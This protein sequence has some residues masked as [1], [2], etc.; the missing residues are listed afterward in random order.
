[1]FR[2]VFA[3]LL[4][5]TPFSVHAADQKK[6]VLIAGTKDPNHPVGTHEYERTV[7]LLKYGLESSANLRGIAC[8]VHFNG[9]PKDETTL[10]TADS[11]V[12]VSSGSDRRLEDH[13]LLLGERMKVIGKQMKRGCGLVTIHWTTFF[14]NSPQGDDVLE[15]VGGHFDYQSGKTAN[16]WASAITTTTYD[17]KPGTPGHPVLQGVQPFKI[18]D[19]FYYQ[20]RFRKDDTRLKPLLVVNAPNVPK[21]QTVGWAVER[22][23]GGRGFGF[24]GGHFFDN[25]YEPNFR[26]LVMNAIAWTAKAEIPTGGVDTTTLDEKTLDLPN[27]AIADWTP[28]PALG[29]AEPWERK[30]D[31]DWDDARFR[32]MDT[33]PFFNAT[34]QYRGTRTQNVLVYKGLAVK[35]E[36]GGAMF[37]RATCEWV[38]GWSGGFLNHSNKRFGLLNTPTPNGALRFVSTASRSTIPLPEKGQYLGLHVHG[39]RVVVKFR[40]GN[41][42]V[43]ESMRSEGTSLIRSQKTGNSTAAVIPPGTGGNNAKPDDFEA[44]TKPGP[45]RWGEPLVTKL[46]RGPE[47]GPFRTDTLT[48]PYDNRFKALFFCTSLDFLPDNRIAVTTCHGDVWLVTVDEEKNECRWQ[49]FATGLYHPFGIKQIDGKL[50]VLERGQLTRLHDHNSDG[51]ADEYECLCNN[52]HTGAGEHS[53]D[54]GLETDPQGNFYFFKT[55]DTELPTGGTLLRVSKDGKKVELFSTGFRHPIGLG[56]SP[57]G[58]VTGADQEGNWMPATRVDQYKPGG[59]YGDMRAHHRQIQPKIFDGPL[60]WLPREVDNSAGGQ[61]WI[62]KS[63]TNWGELAG[64]PLHLSYGRCKAFVL[65]RQELADGRVQ[66]G[67]CD[68]G[69]RFLS[70]VC[71]GRVAPDGN[72]YVCG[73]TGW[74]TA[75][76]QDGCLQRVVPSGKP[77]DAVVSHAVTKTGIRLTFARELDKAS[78]ENPANYKSAQ[79]NYRWVGEYGSKR[80]KPSNPNAE[81]QDEVPIASAKLI[82]GRTIELT[83]ASGIRPVMQ[84]QVGYNVKSAD[85]KVITGSVYLTVHG[86]E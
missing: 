82:D 48:V 56:M 12:L 65:L 54:T 50:V 70:G 59:F 47:G 57:E 33:G 86:T 62:P 5:L 14:P 28:R 19:E 49:R 63:A 27:P 61:V 38:A 44:L 79:W 80:W 1:M 67:V 75:A 40:S 17:C 37:D 30:K 53:Y 77:F 46:V 13:P 72:L 52:W 23:D 15:W 8:E 24:T 10:D 21:D 73:L 22:K 20:L 81:G 45:K 43:L 39:N 84:W 85:G 16:K 31:P 36:N 66:G 11:I 58:I 32:L 69:M 51:E 60:C 64:K 26:R 68:L 2:I 3:L 4:F 9:W 78:V 34:M 83:F 35:L 25:W 74:Q 76:Q 55:G 7:K 29:Q 6:I 18:K 42:T 71:R 41:A